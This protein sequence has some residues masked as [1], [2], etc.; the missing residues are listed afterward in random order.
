MILVGHPTGNAFVRALLEA[1]EARR[2]DYLFFTTL[3]LSQDAWWRRVVPENLGAELGRRS[4]SI[5]RFRCR[6]KPIRELARLLARRCLP[7]RNGELFG[8]W[9]SIDRVYAE[10]DRFVAENIR[11]HGGGSG[12]EAV[13][14]YEDGC[15]TTFAAARKEGITCCYELP[16]AYWKTAQR[17][18]QEE[19]ARWPDWEPTLGATRDPLSKLER[20]TLE[21]SL[22]DIVICPSQFVLDSLPTEEASKK[23]C[24]VAEF[25]TPAAPPRSPGGREPAH[26]PLRLLFAGTLTQRKGLADLFAA[27]KLL[28]RADVELIVMGS[29]AAPL[30][31]YRSCYDNWR[32]EKPRPH[33]AVLDLMKTCDILVLPSIVEGR[34]LVQQEAMICGLPILVTPHAGGEDLVEPG[35]TGF[36]VPIRSPEAIA[37][38]INW[39]AEHRS[40]LPAMSEKARQKAALYTWPRYAAKI[41]DLLG[42]EPPRKTG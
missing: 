40:A 15:A 16:I 6:Q 10:L 29:L 21:L 18:L 4:F 35:E 31:F 9:L 37:E 34:A 33:G 28:R 17:L 39:F 8:R 27:L 11:R 1:L 3:A 5:P 36:V 32:Y 24:L 23:L 20:K 30:S 13:Y 26:G 2:A 12:V 14:G 41:L 19:A 38:K 42:L 25:G 7:G 22:A